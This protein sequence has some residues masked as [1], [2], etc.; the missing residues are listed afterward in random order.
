MPFLV[1]KGLINGCSGEASPRFKSSN[2]DMH[3]IVVVDLLAD[4]L[5]SRTE[6][7]ANVSCTRRKTTRKES[8]KTQANRDSAVIVI[9]YARYVTVPEYVG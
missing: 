5:D 6:E 2:T 4:V 3:G 7:N 8:V 9:R 1:F